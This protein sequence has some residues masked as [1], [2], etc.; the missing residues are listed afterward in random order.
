MI[1]ASLCLVA[2]AF[3]LVPFALHIINKGSDNTIDRLLIKIADWHNNIL[4]KRKIINESNYSDKDF[5]FRSN[6]YNIISTIIILSLGVVLNI[7]SEILFIFIVLNILRNESGGYHSY[8]NLDFC[9]IISI[10]SLIICSFISKYYSGSFL[11]FMILAIISMIY[12]FIKTP[13]INLKYENLDKNIWEYKINF[14]LIA[15]WF[16]ILSFFLPQNLQNCVFLSISIV[17]LFMNDKINNFLN[18]LRKKI[19]NE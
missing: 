15:I 6:L 19:F 4:R 14:L 2:L 8:G 17:A 13:K 9:L 12:T 7:F 16:F 1:S 11:Y 3:Q 5:I 18:N 10:I